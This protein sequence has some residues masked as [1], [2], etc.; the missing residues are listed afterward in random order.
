MRTLCCLICLLFV[1]CTVL[2]SPTPTPKPTNTPLPTPTHPPEPFSA[3][4][5]EWFLAQLTA[6]TLNDRPYLVNEYMAQ[7]PTTPIVHGNRAFFLWRGDAHEVGIVGDMNNWGEPLAMERVSGSDFWWVSAEFEPNARLDYLI[8]T[9]ESQSLDQYNP[10]TVNSG[11]GLRSELVMPEYQLPPEAIADAIYP[12]GTISDHTI[13]SQF[14]GE[15][16]T[17]FVYTPPGEL[18]GA[19]FPSVYFHDGSDYLNLIDTR[20]TLD[21]LIGSRA[22]PPIVAV[23]IPPTDRT[24]EYNRN[25]AYVNFVVEEVVPLVQNEYN[26]DPD[27]TKTATL[28]ASMGGLISLY[29]AGQHPDTFGLVASQSGAVGYGDDAVID[30][31]DMPRQLPLRLHLLIGT[32]ET[33]IVTSTGDDGDFLAANRRLRDVLERRGY[34]FAYTEAP[35]GH[36]WGLWA[37]HIGEAL[38]FLY[39]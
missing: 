34:D 10:R 31:F 8:Q 21:R 36:S 2:E 20:T 25:D 22:I 4:G 26:T 1:S 17:I 30:M 35:E 33:G 39:R 13:D 7:V 5:F 19:K 37:T 27:P 14:L 29:I 9:N 24:I 32:Y 3:A 28:G 11:F 12:A 16:R 6:A 38:R 23:F 15:T 18:I